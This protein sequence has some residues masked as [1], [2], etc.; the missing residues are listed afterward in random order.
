MLCYLF[1]LGGVELY[2]LVHEMCECF[3]MQMVYVMC[4]SCGSHQWCALHDFQ[5][6]YTGRGYKRLSYR[7]G[8]LHACLMTAL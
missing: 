8:I 6:V 4:A 1:I 7:R 2:M 3:V 5:F